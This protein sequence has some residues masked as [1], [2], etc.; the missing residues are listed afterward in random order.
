MQNFLFEFRE[1]YDFMFGELVDKPKK[2]GRAQLRFNGA[3]IDIS[4]TLDSVPRP[5]SPQQLDQLGFDAYSVDLIDGP[6]PVLVWLCD[7]HQLSKVPVQLRK[8]DL[9]TRAIEQSRSIQRYYTRDGSVAVKFSSYGQKFAQIEQRTLAPAKILRAGG[10][11][12]FRVICSPILPSPT[13]L[14]ASC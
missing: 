14:C 2:E 8:R 6:E 1:D 3:E 13:N 10:T 11:S 12:S 5:L 9:D 4:R 7:N